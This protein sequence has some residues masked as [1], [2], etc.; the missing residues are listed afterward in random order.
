MEICCYILY[1]KILDHYY[2]GST[3]DLNARI[4]RHI[5]GFYGHKAFTGKAND[6]VLYLSLP[7]ESIEQALKIERKIKKMKSR[8][9]IENL[10]LY[11]EMVEKILR[12]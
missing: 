7:C 1:S 2:V 3:G 12:E 8:Q 10:R 4:T 11:P 9:Y 6:W 5:Q